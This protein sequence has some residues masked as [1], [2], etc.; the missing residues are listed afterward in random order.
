MDYSLG[1][2]RYDMILGCDILSELDI[3]LYFYKNKIIV[4]RVAY[5]GCT[6]LMKDISKIN[7]NASSDWI[8]D[9]IFRN[10]KLW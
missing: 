6:V 2:H 1:N 9:K 7:L 10:E 5:K 3:D 4:N 8:K